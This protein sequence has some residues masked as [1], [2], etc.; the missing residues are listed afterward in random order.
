MSHPPVSPHD[1]STTPGRHSRSWRTRLLRASFVIG[2]GLIAAPLAGTLAAGPASALGA[3][4]TITSVSPNAGFNTGGT[5]VTITGTNLQGNVWG[6]DNVCT[7]SSGTGANGTCFIDN[8]AVGL[9]GSSSTVNYPQLTP[10]GSGELYFGEAATQESPQACGAPSSATTCSGGGGFTVNVTNNTNEVTFN[11]AVSAQV[12]PSDTQRPAG[13]A[14][15]LAAL[16]TS[17]TGPISTVGSPQDSPAYGDGSYSA[18]TFPVTTTNPGDLLVVS[19]HSKSASDILSSVSGGGVT[20][21]TRAVRLSVSSGDITDNEIWY[22]VVTSPGTTNITVAGTWPSTSA[23]SGGSGDCA[24][25][26]AQ[27]FTAPNTGNQITSVTFGGRSA[28]FTVNSQSQITATAPPG[29]G[30]ADIQVTNGNGTSP[31]TAS[32]QFTY[33]Q[34]EPPNPKESSTSVIQQT[35]GAGPSVFVRGANGSLLNFWYIPS[36]GTWG[37]GT[38]ESGGV[39]S[40]PVVVPQPN[41]APSV[42]FEKANGALM[43]DWYVAGQGVWGSATV[44]GSGLAGTPVV[45]LQP[46]GSPSVFAQGADHSLRNYWYIPAGGLWGA[47]IVSG[48]NTVFSNPAVISQQDG[49]PSV[50]FEGLSNTLVN[51]WYVSAQGIWGSATVAGPGT[52]FSDPGIIAQTNDAPSVFVDG[53]GN[54]LRNYWYI[55]AGGIWGAATLSGGGTA[56]STPGV[57]AQ[58]NGA[59]S[60]FVVGPGNSLVNYWYVPAGGLWGAGTVA[61]GGSAASGPAVTT[62]SDGSPSIFVVSPH[63]ALINYWYI[64]SR[65]IWGAGTVASGGIA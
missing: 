26:V 60:V 31:V 10:A 25:F 59:P 34:L 5:K 20:T 30:T 44:V 55:P 42:F 14:A 7:S 38:V 12:Q 41:G 9:A 36:L 29:S 40:N 1:M 17:S 37:E 35:N 53:P 50:F 2:S 47:A 3:A 21:W 4:P 6:V 18:T 43:N 24:E 62:Q 13:P 48:G 46:N 8:E 32:D 11:P 28:S 54:S 65:G 51:D 57:L 39:V 27:E 15:S 45:T 56:F 19:A 64:A 33:S 49:A 22:G 58:T 23:C 61:G 52:A 63:G 16:F